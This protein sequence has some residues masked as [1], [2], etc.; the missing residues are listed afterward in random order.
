MTR[1][2]ES[3]SVHPIVA[4]PSHARAIRAVADLLARLRLDFIF[5]GSV[6]RAAHLGVRVTSGSVDVIVIMGPQQKNQVAMMAN[7]NGFRLD[8]DEVEAAEELD[9]IPM[10]FDDVRVYILVASNAL[11]GRM[12]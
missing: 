7:N 3:R 6:A 4:D 5:A 9:V 11:Y 10:A 2:V 8:R 1:T 12:V